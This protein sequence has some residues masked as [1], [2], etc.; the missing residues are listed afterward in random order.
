MSRGKTPWQQGR[1]RH[2]G[3]VPPGKN[4]SVFWSLPIFEREKI[5]QHFKCKLKRML[6]GGYGCFASAGAIEPCPTE[7]PAWGCL[8]TLLPQIQVLPGAR[9]YVPDATPDR[10]GH[11]SFR[12]GYDADASRTVTHRVWD[13]RRECPGRSARPSGTL[14]L[15]PGFSTSGLSDRKNG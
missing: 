4:E 10:P 2:G 11:N 7:R 5:S 3:D 14:F 6:R 15:S 12:P 1:Q 8:A 13:G 9:R